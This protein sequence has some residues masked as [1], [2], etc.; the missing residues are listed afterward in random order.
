LT[1]WSATTTTSSTTTNDTFHPIADVLGF[2]F[3]FFSE[4]PP[5]SLSLFLSLSP[6]DVVVFD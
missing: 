6:S 1:T 5:L 4:S 2:L 3:L